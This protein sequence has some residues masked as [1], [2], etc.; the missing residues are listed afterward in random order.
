MEEF[1]SALDLGNI[2]NM[3]NLT[4]VND[5]YEEELS[6]VLDHCAAEQTKFVIMKEKGPWFDEDVANL[7]R[8]LRKI[9]KDLAEY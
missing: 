4:L 9:L 3:E 2:K 8:L 7:R 6:R 5:K 1:K